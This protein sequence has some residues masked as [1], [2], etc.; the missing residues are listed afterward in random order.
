MKEDKA[1]DVQVIADDRSLEELFLALDQFAI[2]DVFDGDYFDFDDEESFEEDDNVIED[3]HDAEAQEEE[4]L[5]DSLPLNAA[6]YDEDQT[7]IDFAKNQMK[8]M[9]MIR[10]Q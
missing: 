2:S 1:E 7:L 8:R 6:G 5:E 10:D 4:D 9:K 3:V